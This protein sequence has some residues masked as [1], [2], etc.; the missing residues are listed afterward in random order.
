MFAF[1]VPI[2]QPTCWEIF[3]FDG[4]TCRHNL[5]GALRERMSLEPLI[6]GKAFIALA[7]QDCVAQL[8]AK[9]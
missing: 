3:G 8:A 6:S 1:G 7:F 4:P 2:R 5:D 9:E